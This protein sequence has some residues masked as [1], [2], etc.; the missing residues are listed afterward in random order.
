MR[1][2]AVSGVT[3]PADSSSSRNGLTAYGAAP[4]GRRLDSARSAN[5]SRAPTVVR[6][7]TSLGEADQPLDS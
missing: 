2:D 4:H 3:S 6:S 5:S 1:S 7:T